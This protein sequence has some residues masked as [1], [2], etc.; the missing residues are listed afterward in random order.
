MFFGSKQVQKLQNT[1]LVSLVYFIIQYHGYDRNEC[2]QKELKKGKT[3]SYCYNVT[4]MKTGKK[5]LARV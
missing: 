3:K 1:A 4:D 5:D 2:L